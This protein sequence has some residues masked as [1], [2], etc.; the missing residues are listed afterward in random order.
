MPDE[1]IPCPECGHPCSP[2]AGLA[3]HRRHKHGVAAAKKKPG[4][5]TRRIPGGLAADRTEPGAE[6]GATA[7]A[8][9]EA[10][11]ETIAEWLRESA[12]EQS[13][14]MVGFANVM[15]AAREMRLAYIKQRHQYLRAAKA[16]EKQEAAAA[17]PEP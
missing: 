15:E 12:R 2:G 10:A 9:L 6:D 5:A 16:V 8:R 3:A 4:V 11:F 13:V 1:K 7:I 14:V 17:V